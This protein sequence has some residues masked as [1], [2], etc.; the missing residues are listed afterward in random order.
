MHGLA[1]I[2]RLV[3]LAILL[4]SFAEANLSNQDRSSARAA[5]IEQAPTVKEVII[6][7]T[8]GLV[9]TEGG[10]TTTFTVKL[11]EAPSSP[12]KIPLQSSDETEGILSTPLVNLSGG[13]WQVGATVTITGVD[14]TIVDGNIAYTI[15]TGPTESRDLDYNG[16]DPADVSVTNMDDEFPPIARDDSDITDEDT[17]ITT[18]VLANDTPGM[19]P[20][21]LTI[22]TAPLHGTAE[23][24]PPSPTSEYQQ[25]LYTPAS[26][27]N[28]VDSYI[29]QL[30]NG[31][32][33]CDTATVNITI[34]PVNDPPVATNDTYSTNEDTQ[35]VVPAPGLL[36]NDTDID[37]D[38]LV[39]S[40]YTQPSNGAVSASA[41]GGF[42]YSPSAN[43]NGTD[44]FTY[45]VSDGHGGT[46][47]ANATITVNPVNDAPKANS[48]SVTTAINTPITIDVLAN[49]TDVDGDT[50]LLQ[51]FET[52]SAHGGIIERVDNGTIGNLSDD[53]VRYTPYPGFYGSDTFHY[54]V[55][56]GNGGIAVGIV[57]ITVTHNVEAPI[58]ND[59]S[60]S[61]EQ[62]TT[63]TVPFTDG[64]LSNDIDPQGQT[65]S[66]DP[67]SVTIP[68]HGDL[69]LNADGSFTYQPDPG[70]YGADTFT[71]RAKNLDTSS[72]IATVTLTINIANRAPNATDDAYSVEQDTQ[73]VVTA[74]NGVL[75]ND[76][77]PDGNGIKA[78]LVTGTSHGTVVLSESGSFTY[79]PDSGFVGTD[80]FTYKA[81]DTKADSNVATVTISVTDNQIPTVSWKLP[82]T[83]GRYD[84]DGEIIHLEVLAQDNV[85]VTSVR[86]FRWDALK[87]GYFDI[88]TDLVQPYQCDINT[89]ILP[90][91]WNQIFAKAYDAAGN[92]SVRQSIFLF[93]DPRLYF[94]MAARKR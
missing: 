30:C 81:T 87:L 72:N 11:S 54:T 41:N 53:K 55:S 8:E 70:Y 71:Y 25:I 64:V 6:T 62:N 86:F 39:V 48:D 36:A 61:L 50:L 57:G 69:S 4:S 76:S 74:P 68:A 33:A 82:V 24:I 22:Q 51:S 67:S 13:N 92:S 17:P 93:R 29:Y 23:V 20:I 49:D 56:D 9:T 85:G 83:A 47:H 28:G 18:D 14:D 38:T 66:V 32:R 19:L 91:M 2:T 77:D 58:A 43:F 27:Y 34:D 40:E 94:P 63:L 52:T 7:P 31:T 73:L 45:T 21:T 59:D 26:N 75:A 90:M 35:L 79:D 46:A 16:L 10:G 80:S 89:S 60:Y 44:S 12:V 88:C 37:G 65:L 78:I 5:I 84:V 3:V 42:T 1:R 15:L